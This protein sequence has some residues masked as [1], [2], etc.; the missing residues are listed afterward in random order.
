MAIRHHPATPSRDPSTIPRANEIPLRFANKYPAVPKTIVKLKI[1][2]NAK[3]K[4]EFNM[5]CKIFS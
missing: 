3:P 1:D 5:L 4:R 2:I